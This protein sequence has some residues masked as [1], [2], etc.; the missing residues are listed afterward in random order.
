MFSRS[1]T[2]TKILEA[3]LHKIKRLILHRRE[4]IKS[5]STNAERLQVLDRPGCN[6]FV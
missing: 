6:R 5:T 1:S 4:S 2:V 3:T